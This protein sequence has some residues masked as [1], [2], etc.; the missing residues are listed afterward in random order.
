MQATVATV[1]PLGGHDLPPE[2]GLDHEPGHDDYDAFADAVLET[3]VLHDPWVDGR[4]RFR[5]EPLIL[6]A[7]TYATLSDVA[8]RIG[9]AY[10]ALCRR[11]LAEPEL[12][13]SY[14]RL[15]PTQRALWE[16]SAPLWHGLARADV[17][18]T[19]D[20]P[21]VCELN[22]D[23]PTGY[24]E[25]ILLNQLVYPRARQ[26]DPT[27]IDPNVGFAARYVEMAET[28]WRALGDARGDLAKRAV[29]IVYPTEMPEDLS[30]I[31]LLRQWFEQAGYEVILGSPFN[32][33]AAE[34]GGAALFGRSCGLLLRHYKTDWWGERE[35]VWDD[36]EAFPDPLPLLHE[37]RIVA[38]AGVQGRTVTVNPFGSVVPQNKRA[39]AYLWEHRATFSAETRATIEA[40]LP[41]T[42]RLET[43]DVDTLVRDRDAW[44]LKSDY[45]CEG[46]EVI[47]GRWTNDTLWRAS[48]AHAVEGRWI[49]QRYFHA[50]TDAAGNNYNFGVYLLAGETAGI[51]TRAQQGATDGDAQSV[52]TLVRGAAETVR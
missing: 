45:G 24:A 14:F 36:D 42:H 21:K 3:G 29:G 32:L 4:P 10:E 17:F 47:V 51:Y 5:Q 6:A 22:C 28:L 38:E 16:L 27:L 31:R 15:T 43:L 1:A 52:P 7:S 48:L 13:T 34:D 44:V 40:F 11:V 26:T 37:L 19:A 35:P 2:P 9:A 8:E 49:A 39:M 46:E 50:D 33:A 20:G 30:V 41:E 23:T 25:A 12:L 18:L